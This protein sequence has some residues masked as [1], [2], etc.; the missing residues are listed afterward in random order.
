MPT[1]SEALT[2]IRIERVPH[3]RIEDVDFANVPFSSVFSDHMFTA[4]F[5]DGHWG[6]GLIQPYGPISVSPSISALH[7]GISVFEGMKAYRS[8]NGRPLL[9][10][11][12]RP[13]AE[14]LSGPPGNANCSRIHVPGCCPGT[15]PPGPGLDPSGRLRSH[16]YPADSFFDRPIAAGEA[17]R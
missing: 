7:Y 4:E 5:R 14:A 8:S 10:Q 3:S 6:E 9:F 13:P 1:T 17:C 11:G 15:R 16:V 2:S 12:K